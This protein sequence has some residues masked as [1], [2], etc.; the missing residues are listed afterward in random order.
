MVGITGPRGVALVGLLLLLTGCD[1]GLGSSLPTTLEGAWLGEG[2]YS[3][4]AGSM[5]VKAQLELLSDGTYRFLI[6]EPGV[7]AMMGGEQGQW[8]RQGQTL[9]LTPAPPKTPSATPDD[10]VFEQ[11]RQSSAASPRPPKQLT[12][13]GNLADLRLDEGKL[14]I[15]FTPNPDATAKLRASG[16]VTEP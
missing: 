4:R 8:S 9:T 1:G 14:A 7:L 15:T 6:L 16:E 13:A 5:D 3:T 2:Q 10:S 11:L 12:V